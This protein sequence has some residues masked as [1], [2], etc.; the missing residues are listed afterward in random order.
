V[1]S[2]D[3]ST[4][5]NWTIAQWP[6]AFNLDWQIGVGLTNSGSFPT[7]P[8]L[9]TT[10]ANGYAMLDSDGANN[11]SG[12]EESAF[13]TTAQPIDLSLNSNVIL[14][15]ENHFRRFPPNKCFVVISTNN[16]DWP[17][18]DS[19]SDANAFPNVWEL[20]TNVATNASTAN[21]ETVEINISSVAGGQSQVWVRFH[22]T[23]S[24]GYAWFLD[25][26]AIIDQP[27]F[28]LVMNYGFVSHNGIGT[29]FG[30]VP[31]DQLYPTMNVGAE[32]LNFGAEDQ[33]N[34]TVNMSVLNAADVEVF[35]ATESFTNLASGDTILMDQDVTIPALAEGVYRAIFTVTSDQIANEGTP[36]NNTRTR[37][38]SINNDVYSLDGIDVYPMAELALTS[39]GTNSFTDAEDEL[40]LLTYY[41]LNTATT[42]Y[43]VEALLANG[44]VVNSEAILTIHTEED[45]N[46][47]N[48][49]TP[50]A[51]SDFIIVSSANL[52]QGFI[53][54]F[55]PGGVELPA[56]N[57]YVGIKLFS[58]A[59]TNNIRILDDITVP[60]PAG[61]SL[62]HI[63]GDGV[64][65]NGN[66]HALRMLLDPT[67]G[68]N[69][70]TGELNGITMYPN[71]T[72]GQLWIN[73]EHQGMHIV[74]VYDMVGSLV[75]TGNFNHLTTI[76]LGGMAKGVYNVR[77]ANDQ[78]ATARRITVQ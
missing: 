19:G 47:D 23:G 78:G 63:P 60:Q 62:I 28:D 53:R 51:E 20:F 17:N 9:S 14:S 22:W 68:I 64:F 56:D 59:G 33:T 25:D 1:W 39:L 13:I 3:F 75:Y 27:D 6:G 70:A 29:E 7:A 37:T 57:Y 35:N 61:A 73:T 4:P 50:L 77:I 66:A 10:A 21:P 16:T 30:R 15:F 72:D 52:S 40:M 32:V 2:D 65:T 74:E 43:G 71:P 38:F 42:V 45:I 26:V 34:L 5:S 55:F 58:Q 46:N 48:V 44:T 76:E 36:N 67:V 8:I 18:L 31:Q 24:Y 12:I 69:E 11:T 54:G 41:E 49:N